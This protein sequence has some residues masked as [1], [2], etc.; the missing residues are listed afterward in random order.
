MAMTCAIF[1]CTQ[2]LLQMFLYE[3]VEF[4]C[5]PVFTKFQIKSRFGASRP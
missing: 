5:E 3:R 4:V 1:H 2:K